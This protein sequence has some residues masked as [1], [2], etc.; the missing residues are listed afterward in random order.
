LPNHAAAGETS[1][2][3]FGDSER[4]F[5]SFSSKNHATGYWLLLTQV[6]EAFVVSFSDVLKCWLN[7][8]Y[9]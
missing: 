3:T 4:A 9:L 7:L 2:G 6:L 1:S 5:S 8:S